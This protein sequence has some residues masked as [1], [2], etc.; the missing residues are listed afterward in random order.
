LSAVAEGIESDAQMARLRAMGYRLG[1]GSHL[2]RPLPAADAGALLLAEPD[3][4][5]SLR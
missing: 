5:A 2:A 3:C 4:V 1:Q